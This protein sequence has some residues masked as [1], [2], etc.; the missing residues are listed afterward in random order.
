M[1]L[2]KWWLG[3]GLAALIQGL[4]YY[5]VIHLGPALM[6]GSMILAIVAL[7]I[8]HGDFVARHPRS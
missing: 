8:L 5:R 2:N 6:V 1:K 4:N 3:L 7:Y